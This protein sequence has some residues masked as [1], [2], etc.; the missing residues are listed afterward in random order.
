[1]FPMSVNVSNVCQSALCNPSI[2]RA[3]DVFEFPEIAHYAFPKSRHLLSRD[4][5]IIP[6]IPQTTPAVPHGLVCF[7]R[8]VPSCALW[9]KL[10]INPKDELSVV[11]AL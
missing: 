10:M 1:M 5:Y 7:C 3:R 9:M 6:F 4:V 8:V 2:H 11:P